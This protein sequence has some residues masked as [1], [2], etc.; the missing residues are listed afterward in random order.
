MVAAG[1]EPRLDQDDAGAL[2]AAYLTSLEELHQS[3]ESR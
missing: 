1:A 2:I 3:A